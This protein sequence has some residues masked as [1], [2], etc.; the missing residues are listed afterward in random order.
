[1][2]REPGN[3]AMTWP[4]FYF[5]GG[6]VPGMRLCLEL[7]KLLQTLGGTAWNEAS[8]VTLANFPIC[9]ESHIT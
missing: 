5:S 7:E 2:R 4:L 8:L 9:A 1:M 3:E 6:V